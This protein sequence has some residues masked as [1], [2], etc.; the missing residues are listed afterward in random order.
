[1]T[2]GAGVDRNGIVTLVWES[3]TL[4]SFRIHG[5]RYHP[6]VGWS[7][8]VLLGTG[9][10]VDIGLWDFDMAVG[11]GGAVAVVWSNADTSVVSAVYRSPNGAW[12]RAY[13]LP[14]PRWPLLTHVTVG[15]HGLATVAYQGRDRHYRLLQR[16]GRRWQKPA[17]LPARGPQTFDIDAG[18]PGQVVMAWLGRRGTFRVGT[19]A[20]GSWKA[21]RL[22]GRLHARGV[23]VNAIAHRAT[24]VVLNSKELLSVRQAR[25]GSIAPPVV[26]APAGAA[27]TGGSMVSNRHGDLMLAW[28]PDQH[29]APIYV[30]NKRPSAERWTDPVDLSAGGNAVHCYGQGAGLSD[31][32]AAVVTWSGSYTRPGA[33]TRVRGLWV[34]RANPAR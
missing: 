25:D 26:I 29:P 6:G 16:A 10:A 1:M 32:G 21:Q 4:D 3:D 22:T 23:H 34:R 7:R 28:I 14:S 11:A 24:T 13:S 12:S 27:C 17:V 8:P 31:A 2:L 20:S 18:S 30:A 33:D 19:F 15:P 5:S 9:E